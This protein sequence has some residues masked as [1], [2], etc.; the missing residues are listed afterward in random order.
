MELIPTKSGFVSYLYFFNVLSCNFRNRASDIFLF[1]N[2]ME[3]TPW[4][5]ASLQFAKIIFVGVNF[6]YQSSFH[7]FL[8]FIQNEIQIVWI[9]W[10]RISFRRGIQIGE[11]DFVNGFKVERVIPHFDVAVVQNGGHHQRGTQ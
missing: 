3:F 10:N 4:I 6:F 8:F 7:G 11:P 1:S 2:G 5:S 9:D